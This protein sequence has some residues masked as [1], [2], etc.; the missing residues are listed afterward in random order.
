MKNTITQEDADLLGQYRARFR[1]IFDVRAP[2]DHTSE[3]RMNRIITRPSSPPWVKKTGTEFGDVRCVNV[4]IAPS[5]DTSTL[6]IF[7]DEGSP[8]DETWICLAV[9]GRD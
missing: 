5:N 9:A 1:I 2:K 3:A 8:S 7:E 4:K 6:T